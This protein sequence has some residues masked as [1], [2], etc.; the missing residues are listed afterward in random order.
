MPGKNKADAFF[1]YTKGNIILNFMKRLATTLCAFGVLVNA[2]QGS[3]IEAAGSQ[4]FDGNA[5]MQAAAEDGGPGSE[6]A[7]LW[8]QVNSPMAHVLLPDFW[9]H[10]VGADGT[11]KQMLQQSVEQGI[12]V[13]VQ[14]ENGWSAMTFAA[15]FN[16]IDAVHMLCEEFHANVNNMENDEWTP[17]L[18]ASYHGH[19]PLI[20]VLIEKYGADISLLNHEGVGSATLLRHKGMFELAEQVSR[21]GLA[22]AMDAQTPAAQCSAIMRVLKGS[23]SNPDAQGRNIPRPD[24][25]YATIQNEMGWAPLHFC[26]NAGD[27]EAIRT[28]L[29]QYSAEIN[30]VENDRWS[31]L[32][33]AVFHGH[34]E[35]V[36][37]ILSYS[38][39]LQKVE[40]NNGVF[41]TVDVE[42]RNDR[43]VQVQVQVQVQMFACMLPLPY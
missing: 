21:R 4:A 28:L 14:N 18:F 7:T 22:D 15:E 1:Y 43:W 23:S 29:R 37:E 5:A 35:A 12:S 3:V 27:V 30:V 20:R 32:M 19:E 24:I 8:D 39:T 9:R 13:D 33:F 41:R 17:L 6:A 40:D 31:P 10:N 34:V 42:R 38:G 2:A 11:L 25:N 16:D 36:A 26:A